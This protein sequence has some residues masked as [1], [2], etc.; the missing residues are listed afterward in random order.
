MQAPTP[1]AQTQ[2]S[3][4]SD[5]FS[6]EDGRSNYDSLCY[7]AERENQRY[8]L[9][10]SWISQS[11]EEFLNETVKSCITLTSD[12]RCERQIP[13]N[14]PLVAALKQII[15]S[16]VEHTYHSLASRRR[17][18]PPSVTDD[19][20][21]DAII[22]IEPTE[23][24]WIA[25]G[26]RMTAQQREDAAKRIDALIDYSKSDRIVHGMLILIRDENLDKPASLVAER[27]GI[28]EGEVYVARKRLATLTSKYLKLGRVA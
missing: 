25:E 22:I 2:I 26:D 12:G 1:E 24:F 14:V 8:A 16:K 28:S 7:Y 27:L 4:I 5:F 3:R 6:G 23:Q 11:G 10:S 9:R 15:K 17:G 13:E 21:D 20:G 19:S 18:H